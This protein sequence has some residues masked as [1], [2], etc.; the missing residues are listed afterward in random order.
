MIK[1]DN[2]LS[3]RFTNMSFVCACLVVL[4][5]TPITPDRCTTLYWV[6]GILGGD[7]LSRI[8]VPFFFLASG[9]FLQD[10]YLRHSGYLNECFKRIRTLVLPFLCWNLF[11]FLH[12]Y[13]IARF[14]IFLGVSFPV[15]I[16]A[17]SCFADWINLLGFN[18]FEGSA[19]PYMW[20]VR[21]LFLYILIS[22]VLGRIVQSIRGPYI[23][24]ALFVFFGIVVVGCMVESDSAYKFIRHRVSVEGFFYFLLGMRIRRGDGF[25]R[26]FF[27]A[28]LCLCV[29]LLL[30]LVRLMITG[31]VLTALC[32]W[33]MI[34]LI[35]YG[36]W[37]LMPPR[38]LLGRF[39][40]YSFPLYCLHGF[41]C[42][43]ISGLVSVCG[44]KD[45]ALTSS[46]ALYFTRWILSLFVTILCV[47]L[48][49]KHAR[50]LAKIFF[51]GR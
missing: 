20:F 24:V 38:L 43:W 25:V 45:F 30:S 47:D 1:L 28:R 12:G 5:H 6:G 33:F 32:T 42:F 9:F 26:R 18:L 29:G 10:K 44:L 48:I 37:G 46:S 21:C 14:A 41:V 39:T 11:F 17:H 19:L 23:L 3:I 22:P 40:Q 15:R 34:P 16:H 27:M 7:G 36:L 49:Y 35:M 31:V 4:I 13:L 2:E 8:A 50:S 51:G